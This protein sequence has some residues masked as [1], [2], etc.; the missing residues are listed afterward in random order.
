LDVQKRI[1]Q[2]G[3]DLKTNYTHDLLPYAIAARPITPSPGVIWSI[4]KDRAERSRRSR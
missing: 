2:N 3:R 4:R 1:E